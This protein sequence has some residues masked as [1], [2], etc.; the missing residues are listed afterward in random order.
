VPSIINIFQILSMKP[1]R[2]LAILLGIALL[3]NAC[4]YD[5]ADLLY[6]NSTGAGGVCDTVGIVSY[7]QKVVP[8]LQT[9]C[10]SCHTVANPSGGIA[11]A[12][13]ATDKAIAVNGKLYGSINHAAGFSPMPKGAGKL[14]S[15]QL[16]TIKKWIDNGS[17]N[18]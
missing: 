13:Y 4:Y 15:C 5:K 12:T 18:N 7:S 3:L 17:L 6:P 14:N 16:A 11:M 1:I 2:S 10:Y 8:I 9:A